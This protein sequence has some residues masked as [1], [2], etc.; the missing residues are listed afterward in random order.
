MRTRPLPLT[1]ET[2]Y[3][4]EMSLCNKSRNNCPVICTESLQAAE[5][6]KQFDKDLTFVQDDAALLSTI[7]DASNVGRWVCVDSSSV[8]MDA[9]REVVYKVWLKS[10]NEHHPDFLTWIVDRSFD[11]PPKEELL[12]GVGAPRLG[13][14]KGRHGVTDPELLLAIEGPHRASKNLPVAIIRSAVYLQYTDNFRDEFKARELIS[15]VSGSEL[16]GTEEVRKN[17]VLL[18]GQDVVDLFRLAKREDVFAALAEGGVDD[19]KCMLKIIRARDRDGKSPL[20]I[21]IEK[22]FRKGAVVLRNIGCKSESFKFERLLDPAFQPMLKELVDPWKQFPFDPVGSLKKVAL[23]GQAAILRKLFQCRVDVNFTFDLYPLAEACESGCDDVAWIVLDRMSATGVNPLQDWRWASHYL[24]STLMYCFDHPKVVRG[25][26]ASVKEIGQHKSSSV[27]HSD[28][29]TATSE[30]ERK[31]LNVGTIEPLS[32][33][34]LWVLEKLADA[35]ISDGVRFPIPLSALCR[36]EKYI[37]IMKKLLLLVDV[38]NVDDTGGLLEFFIHFDPMNE[39]ARQLVRKALTDVGNTGKSVDDD[40]YSLLWQ[41]IRQGDRAV[42]MFNWAIELVCFRNYLPL[43]FRGHGGHTILMKTLEA[44]PNVGALDAILRFVRPSVKEKVLE[45]QDLNGNNA[46]KGLIVK[47]IQEPDSHA[48]WLP[49]YGDAVRLLLDH[50]LSFQVAPPAF[51]ADLF[52]MSARQDLG[53]VCYELLNTRTRRGISVILSCSN[54][55]LALMLR[56]WRRLQS[57]GGSSKSVSFVSVFDDGE[58]IWRSRATREVAT[59]TDGPDSS[60]ASSF[61]THVVDASKPASAILSEGEKASMSR[62]KPDV[63]KNGSDAVTTVDARI[64]KARKPHPTFGHN[65]ISLLGPELLAYVCT[66]SRVKD[67]VSM[68]YSCTTFFYASLFDNVWMQ[69]QLR[70]VI[71]RSKKHLQT[72][73]QHATMISAIGEEDVKKKAPPMA[74]KLPP[75][76]FMCDTHSLESARSIFIMHVAEHWQK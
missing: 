29:L 35:C 1:I 48:E 67:C 12:H 4:R 49:Q 42:P 46:L 2:R 74:A 19:E 70:E 76:N 11:A 54:N 13:E 17:V 66:F 8:S 14:Q 26:S 21:A 62:F 72:V 75:L 43:N 44:P 31:M 15:A 9:L 3:S 65:M 55:L 53:E 39:L 22:D 47:L 23:A 25:P 24:V 5:C 37:D 41:M 61:V 32:S 34:A 6:A 40:M 58:A 36:A 51:T 73:K 28:E 69:R 50:G 56:R 60:T 30:P 52:T 59:S 16:F 10:G 45:Q 20:D 57:P 71:P 27:N 38:L 33:T 18:D 64:E 63:P 68:S 7:V